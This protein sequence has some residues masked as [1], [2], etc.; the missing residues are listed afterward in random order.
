MVIKKYYDEKLTLIR[1]NRQEPRADANLDIDC[2]NIITTSDIDKLSQLYGVTKVNL[3]QV[4]RCNVKVTVSK[5]F[6]ENGLDVLFFQEE[7][8]IR[9]ILP[10]HF[11]VEEREDYMNSKFGIAWNP[12]RIDV[13][14]VLHIKTEVFVSFPPKIRISFPPAI[15]DKRGLLNFWAYT[16]RKS[17][18]R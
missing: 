15:F 3:V 6:D 16:R 4:V 17:V 8:N 12:Q 1:Q 2:D 9:Y 13:D 5:F 7:K 11:I 14:K 10:E 18:F